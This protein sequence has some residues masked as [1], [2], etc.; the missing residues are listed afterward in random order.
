MICQFRAFSCPLM[1]RGAITAAVAALHPMSTHGPRRP[2]MRSSRANIT[3]PTGMTSRVSRVEVSRPPITTVAKGGHTSNSPPVDKASGHRPAMVVALVINTGRVRSLTALMAALPPLQPVDSNFFCMRSTS[4]M[5]GFTV[6]PSRATTPTR[7]INP[8]LRPDITR[9]QTE[10]RM[11][12]GTASRINSG[13]VIDS[14]AI[15]RTAYNNSNTGI[16][17]FLNQLLACSA[18]GASTV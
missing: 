17:T 1:T 6:S 18:A 15:A 13:R 9:A 12:S 7:A 2:K 3:K 10:P 14:N 11:V 4:R 8:A 16:R 5:A